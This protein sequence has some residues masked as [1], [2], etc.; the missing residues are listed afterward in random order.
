MS[1]EVWS[2]L[3]GGPG[4]ASQCCHPMAHR[5]IDSL[6]KSGVEPTREAHRLQCDREICLCPQAHHVRDPQQLAPPVA[7]LHLA[8]DQ[9]RCHLPLAHV[10]PSTTSCEPL[11]KMGCEGIEIH[12]EAV[13][14]EERQ[15]AR[16][17]KLPQGVDD[18]MCC[19]L[20]TGTQMEDGNDLCKGVDG[21]PEPEHV[22]GAAQSCSQLV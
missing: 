4:S 8:V 12:I 13:T 2:L 15:I 1:Q 5:Q 14:G 6:D 19:V 16:N 22:C 3:G 20:C 18:G 7:F 9:A 21:Q 10:P 11:A 17:Q